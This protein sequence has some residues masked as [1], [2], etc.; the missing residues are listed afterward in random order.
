[1]PLPWPACWQRIH[2][3]PRVGRDQR[4][5]W[6]LPD[7]RPGQMGGLWVDAGGPRFSADP[8]ADLVALSSNN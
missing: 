4:E 8:L 5:R 1:M 7:W 2:H 3:Y 6:V